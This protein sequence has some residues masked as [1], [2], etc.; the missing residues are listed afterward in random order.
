MASSHG[1]AAAPSARDDRRH[2][3]AVRRL[4][5]I[6]AERKALRAEGLQPSVSEVGRIQIRNGHP[7]RIAVR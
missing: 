3:L 2:V 1:S 6:V 7:H 5:I 4:H